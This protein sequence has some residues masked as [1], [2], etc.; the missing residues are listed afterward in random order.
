MIEEQGKLNLL[1]TCLF[2]CN[3]L[4]ACLEIL[5]E[6]DRVAEAVLFARTHVPK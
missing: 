2:L 1:F 5:I 3:E 4:E 6:S